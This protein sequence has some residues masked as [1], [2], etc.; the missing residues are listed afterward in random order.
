MANYQV[1]NRAVA[2]RVEDDSGMCGFCFSYGSIYCRE[3]LAALHQSFNVSQLFC[4]DL[5]G[6]SLPLNIFQRYE[7]AVISTLENGNG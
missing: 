5:E 4:W 3:L 1:R 2:R 7:V 6:I